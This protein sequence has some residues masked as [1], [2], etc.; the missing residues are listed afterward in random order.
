MGINRRRFIEI[1]SASVAG[2]LTGCNSDGPKSAKGFLVHAEKR[3]EA[4]ERGLLRHTSM[5]IPRRGARDAGS[6]F[7]SYFISERLP[8][9]DPAVRG[10]WTLEVNGAVK[11]PVKLTLEQLAALPRRTQRVNHYCVEGWN[12]VGTW[13]GVR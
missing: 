13:T 7:P 3:N 9:W 1:S 10:A 8:V 5:D 6:K 12:A 11:R 2:L 4:L